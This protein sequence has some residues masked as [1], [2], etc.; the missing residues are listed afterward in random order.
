MIVE[1]GHYA[2]V[3]GLALSLAQM[4][5]PMIGL[6]TNNARML[7][8]APSLT[9][10]TFLV[11]A[12]SFAAL[13]WAYVTSDFSVRN[14][15]ANSFSDKPLLF[16]ITGVWGNHEGSMLLWILTLALFGALVAFFGGNL[17]SRL[18]AAV[19]SVQG[20]VTV[21]FALFI[22]LTSNPFERL[23]PPPLEGRDLNPILQDIGLAIHPPLLY[24]GYV[25]FSICFSF[26]VAALIEGR[27]DAAWA[28]W[29][30]PWTLVSWVFLTA[31]ISMGSYWAYYELGWGGWWFWDPVENASFMPWL[32][33]T[34]L[35]HSALVMEKREAMKVWTILLAILAFSF[36]LLGTFLV[37]SGVLTSVHSFATDPQR[38][39]FILMILVFFIGGSLILF[40]LRAGTLRNGGMFH[41]VSREGALVLNNL[42]LTTAT[43]TVLVG[44]LYPLLVEAVSG[45]KISVGAP[46]FNYT[47]IPL[48]IPLLM[49][50]PFGPLLAWK[51]GNLAAAAERLWLTAAISLVAALAIAWLIYDAPVLSA[52][53]YALAFWLIV[54]SFADVWQK[55]GF[56]KNGWSTGWARLKGLPRASWGTALAHAGLGITTLG[57]VGVTTLED[58]TVLRMTP[59]ETT[60]FAGYDV[61][62]NSLTPGKGPNF[63]Y[64]KGIFTI[65]RDGR[66]IGTVEP[67]KR[68]YV[69]SRMPT[70]EAGIQTV[71]L[72]SQYY[73]ALGDA[74]EGSEDIVVRIWWKPWVTLIWYG[75]V[76]MVAAGLISLSDR[77]LRIGAPVAARRRR[78]EALAAARA[79]PAE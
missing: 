37:R 1:L 19:L 13:T 34:A 41:P 55:A 5:V 30:R 31:G 36:S 8:V 17:P 46:Y 64:D 9:V 66:V 20:S 68:V 4:I 42:F 48:M 44:T 70:T 39:L 49:A 63:T 38:G 74:V 18:K 12:V 27:I 7:A 51:R 57:I 14:V 54:G 62:F 61:E 15:W 76:V 69:A 50:V 71:G 6:R 2:L 67:E 10:A 79:E 75:T 28:R 45:E 65:S 52:F 43:A 29:V 25:G 26:A 3:L 73:L 16:K 22:L 11:V 53:A 56:V 24:L 35:L 47:F 60:S 32:I 23:S 21:A 59:G 58:E 72:F 33:G 77:R 40:A 78:Q